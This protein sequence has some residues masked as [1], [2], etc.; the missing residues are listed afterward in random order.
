MRLLTRFYHLFILC[1]IPLLA[2]GKGHENPT[3]SGVLPCGLRY[4]LHD[5]NDPPETIAFRLVIS[6]GSLSEQPSEEGA[7]HFLEHLAFRDTRRFPNGSLVAHLEAMGGK[8]GSTIN[9]YTGYDRTVYY[10]SIPSEAPEYFDL[11]LRIVDDWL[12][13]IV[14]TP[15]VVEREKPIIYEEIRQGSE[16]SSFDLAKKG[17]DPRLHRQPVGDISQVRRLNSSVLT[18]FYKRVYHPCRATLVIC[19]PGVATTSVQEQIHRQFRSYPSEERELPASSPLPYN[20]PSFVTSEDDHATRASIDWIV[21]TPFRR[22]HTLSQIV[23]DEFDQFVLYVANRLLYSQGCRGSVSKSWYLEGTD[24]L[25]Y[26]SSEATDSLL[27]EDIERSAG[28]LRALVQHHLGAEDY[29]RLRAS[30]LRKMRKTRF[31]R[32]SQ[33]WAEYYTVLSAIGW[34]DAATAREYE[35]VISRLS[36]YDLRSFHDRATQ[37]FSALFGPSIVEYRYAPGEHRKLSFE[38]IQGRFVSAP[39]LPTLT[40]KSEGEKEKKT[41]RVLAP[42]LSREFTFSPR[43]IADSIYYPAIGVWE[44]RLTNGAHLIVK[45]TP[46]ESRRISASMVF[47]GGLSEIPASRYAELEGVASYMSLGGVQGVKGSDYE[48]ALAQHRLSLVYTM[49][50]SQHGLFASGESD[51]ASV[52]SSLI[53]AKCFYPERCY[54]EFAEIKEE[55]L[56]ERKAISERPMSLRPGSRLQLAIDSIL[57]RSTHHDTELT[58]EGISHLNLDSLGTYY[59]QIYTRSTGLTCI[60]TGDLPADFDI[61]PFAGMLQS[62]RPAFI[63]SPHS[64]PAP[65]SQTTEVSIAEEEDPGRT[66]FSYL[67]RGEC[68]SGLATQLRLKIIRDLLQH[69]LI[70][71]I[72]NDAGL[73]YSPYIDLHY[74]HEASTVFA[75]EIHGTTQ[76]THLQEIRKRIEGII[77]DMLRHAPSDQ[78][79][80]GIKRSFLLTRSSYLSAEA[81]SHWRDHLISCIRDGIGLQEIEQYPLIL[82]EIG[83]RQIL[84]ACQELLSGT[85]RTFVYTRPLE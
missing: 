5:S 75:L 19:G 52:L 35:E 49:D 43:F 16:W 13:G 12:S 48:Q 11:G 66:S 61:T 14:L 18:R 59:K 32:N 33:E 58:A 84:D 3:R 80:T 29:R 22:S 10:F 55:M 47:Q 40:Y 36:S 82:G 60:L 78:R 28:V 23:E 46:D 74:R 54:E 68:P 67:I 17:Y 57:H 9:A 71:E 37:L 69:R 4:I 62:Y 73:I 21:P 53:H 30:Y 85:E 24:H 70:S 34:R 31:E 15:E 65:V 77:E 51:D 81:S 42:F 45:P 2:C 64:S 26:S 6:A 20:L 72:R 79:L 25:C 39:A 63:P 44:Y 7:A 38:E 8:Y 27:L 1:L 83:P 41:S 76:T 50:T 56:E